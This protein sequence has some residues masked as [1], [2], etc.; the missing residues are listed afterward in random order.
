MTARSWEEIRGTLA[1]DE[2]QVAA[3]RDRMLAEVRAQ[4][5]VDLRKAQHLTQAEVAERMGVSQRRVSQ[6]ERGELSR[7]EIGTIESYVEAIGGQVE[8][9]AGFG[10]TRVVVA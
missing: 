3:E 1:V 5:L 6:I 9:V 2:D 4:R 8:V 10:D 7:S